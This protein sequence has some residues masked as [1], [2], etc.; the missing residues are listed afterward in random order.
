MS[1]PADWAPL[2][3]ADP[4]P[5]DPVEVALTGARLAQVAGQISADVSWL[6][7]L[8]TAQFWDSGAGEAFQGQV[9]DAAAR[10][11]KAHERYLAAGQA[12]GSSLTGP[13]YAGALD[14]AQALSL[15]ALTRGQDAWSVMR[16]Q[17]ATAEVANKGFAPYEGATLSPAIFAAQPV[18]DS[19]GNPVLMFTPADAAT[20]LRTAVSRYNASAL[21]YRTANG[22]L[23][24]A[25]AMRDAAAARAAAAIQAALGRDGLQDQTGLW[26]DI[27]S[28]ADASFG[29]AEQHWAQ[30][31]GDIA[32]V[33]GWIASALGVLALIFAF[34]CPPLAA[35]LEGMALTLTE[36]A[37]VCHLILA[38][39]GKG[40]WVDF[41]IDL[42]S[43]ATFGLGR[44][45]LRAGEITVEAADEIS[46]EGI[47][48]RA[49][50]LSEGLAQAGEGEIPAVDTIVAI[51]KNDEEI[52]IIN[53]GANMGLPGILGKFS[54]KALQD[55]K[56]ANPIGAVKTIR[57]TDWA[58]VLGKQPGRTITSAVNQAIHM[59]S[60]EF[61]QAQKE[62]KEVPGLARITKLTGI[63]F[64]NAI[65]RYNHL[66][67]G[68]QVASLS[69][70]AVD[71]TDAVLNYFHKE[72]PGYDWVKEHATT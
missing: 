23:A 42:I 55:F 53:K 56:P 43:L 9:D 48:T 14:Q 33:C 5:G 16:T 41:G 19:S 29:W 3:V 67:V 12:L 1:R 32:T 70:D 11:A 27:T 28:A 10:L 15:R 40:S 37:A 46:L 45:M 49:D 63:N 60:P 7:S 65:T 59:R 64:P 62:L 71:K 8:C 47:A 38:I 69:I 31:V 50:S 61:A 26:H 24:E 36:V 13:G 20:P 52:A 51:A 35:A 18:L 30:V 2:A 17:L 54:E 25:V 4:V 21:D 72:I 57:G 22:W 34:I 66:W 44:N 68:D 39:F 6:R 58:S